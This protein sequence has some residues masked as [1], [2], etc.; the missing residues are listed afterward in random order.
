M[1]SLEVFNRTYG[2]PALFGGMHMEQFVQ[3]VPGEPLLLVL[4]P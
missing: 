3:P 4:A 2:Y 1:E